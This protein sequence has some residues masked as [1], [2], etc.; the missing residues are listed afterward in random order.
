MKETQNTTENIG[1]DTGSNADRDGLDWGAGRTIR[2][3]FEAFTLCMLMA[4]VSGLAFWLLPKEWSWNG[5]QV[6]LLLHLVAGGLAIVLYLVFVVLH[7]PRKEPTG[8]KR[9]LLPWR[10][11]Q[12]KDNNSDDNSDNPAQ[13]RQRRLGHA[14]HWT[15]LF[16]ILTCAFYAVPTIAFKLGIVW[17]AG[18]E[19][20][21]AANAAHLLLSL[22]FVALA[23]AHI[24]LRRRNGADK[25][26][27]SGTINGTDSGTEKPRALGGIGGSA[28]ARRMLAQGAFAL[29]LVAAAFTL[30]PP[31]EPGGI[32]VE[33][34]P[35]YSRPFGTDPFYP[36]EWKTT[37]GK[38]VNWR[39]ASTQTA[40]FCA[41][42]HK[43][44]FRE[45]ASSL[46]AITGPDILYD[47]SIL[48]NEWEAKH[49][50]DLR[51][52]RIRW[53]DSCH[54]PINVLSGGRT[55]FSTVR[56]TSVLEEGAT[57]ILCHSITA[58][59]PLAGNAAMTSRLTEHQ[60]YLDPSLIM[61]APARHAKDM[62]ARRDN[63]LM[64]RSEFCGSCHTEIRPTAV[65]GEFPLHLQETYDEWRRSD[66]ARRGVQCQDCH[67][68]DD[69]AATIAAL[70]AGKP[71]RKRL[72]H[73]IVGNNYL[74]TDTALPYDLLRGGNP[75][76]KNIH[77]RQHE[78]KADL[79]TQNRLIHELLR[80]A[81]DLKLAALP[82]DEKGQPGIAVAITNSGAGHDLPTGPLDQRYLWIEVKASGADGRTLY[83][84][85]W[86]DADKDEE[87][88]GAVKYLKYVYDD[89]G[90]PI[91]RHILFDVKSMAY[92]RKPIAPGATDTVTYRLPA[93]VTESTAPVTVEVRLWYRLAL[94][95]ILINVQKQIDPQL[96]AKIPP[97]EIGKAVL[98]LTPL[99]VQSAQSAQSAQNTASAAG[100][101]E[102]SGEK[103]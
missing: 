77:Y 6:T 75:P 59:D 99:Q 27:D 60:N 82:A 87:D 98:T 25:G 17:L 38:L 22:L 84:S 101:N 93:A 85:G 80:S 45:W 89:D 91:K 9:L 31:P 47:S 54:E 8:W 12:R 71:V 79:D 86:Y 15:M 40:K 70:K 43:K 90:Q 29:A 62:Q 18:Y 76:G 39:A 64:G 97:V 61:A 3:L 48:V 100:N 16:L 21:L 36:A 24:P 72:S 94:K 28:L 32:A 19:T 69:P 102:R 81:A 4:L 13:E 7:Q 42:C 49:G 26:T 53:C 67:M 57:C 56:E 23:L 52:E 83:H 65:N 68:S 46:H 44:E 73:R 58:T 5:S 88:P 50:G 33:N 14:L 37:D 55:P 63:P 1:R 2:P 30:T 34:L 95:E 66:Y 35:F 51:T 96:T 92:T 74:L 103:S 10:M 20:Y 41:D 78:F 11:L